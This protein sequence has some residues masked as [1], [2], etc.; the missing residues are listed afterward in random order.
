[1]SASLHPINLISR[2]YLRLSAD[3]T[4]SFVL[5]DKK[6]HGRSQIPVVGQ[7]LDMM[8][9]GWKKRYIRLFPGKLEWCVIPYVPSWSFSHYDW[10]LVE[11]SDRYCT[12]RYKDET[13]ASLAKPLGYGPLGVL[14]VTSTPPK[15]ERIQTTI[16]TTE[17]SAPTA[18]KRC[19][20]VSFREAG[21]V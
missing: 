1:M 13:P 12:L 21:E 15:F 4:P 6:M 9:A 16:Q 2:T 7:V 3:S 10:L 17:S 18:H 11:A 14:R 20:R 19:L 5:A 8:G